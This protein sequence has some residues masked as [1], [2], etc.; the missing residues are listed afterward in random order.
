MKNKRIVIITGANGGIGF[1]IAKT[2]LEENSSV[3]LPYGKNRDN[4]DKLL[5]EYGETRVYPFH[6]D[7]SDPSQIPSFVEQVDKR[8][9][10]IDSLVNNAGITG[11]GPLEEVTEEAWNK[12]F[13]INL[14]SPFFLIQ[15]IFP[16][17]RKNGGGSIVNIGS[18]SGHEPSP[19]MGPYSISKAGI[20]MMT[21]LMSLEWGP[22]NIRVND[23]SPGL[24]RTPIS[25]K[26][27]QNEKSNRER[28]ELV[29]I[30][31]IGEGK[32]IAS[33]VAFLCSNQ[34]SYITG[35]SIVVDGGLI[36]SVHSHLAGPPKEQME[37]NKSQ[38]NFF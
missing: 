21:R 8:F 7:L 11:P 3:I 4:I 16:I 31:R 34:A 32:D 29:P 5:E 30:Q 20:I 17:M 33:M 6:L 19:G 23:V 26:Y 18:W 24:I 36:N 14:K 38:R 37:K 9:G 28:K 13:N 1:A 12:M 25:E 2:F 27:Y 10:R 15:K 22:F 35:Q